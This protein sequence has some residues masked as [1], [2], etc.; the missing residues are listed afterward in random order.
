MAWL[1]KTAGGAQNTELLL[2]SGIVARSLSVPSV[3]LQV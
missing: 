1:G 2:V 3:A